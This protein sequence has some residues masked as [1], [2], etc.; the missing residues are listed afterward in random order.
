MST[1]KCVAIAALI[2]SVAGGALAQSP[3]P[4]AISKPTSAAA[5]LMFRQGGAAPAAGPSLLTPAP[6]AR[7]ERGSASEAGVIRSRVAALD[8]IG[9]RALL[10]APNLM[11]DQDGRP[12]GTPPTFTL[13]LFDDISVRL[14]K[15]DATEDDFGLVSLRAVLAGDVSGTATLVIDRDTVTGSI[16]VGGRYFSILGA[17]EGRHRVFELDAAGVRTVKDDA[18]RPFGLGESG[19]RAAVTRVIEDPLHGAAGRERQSADTTIT[20]MVSYTPAASQVIPNIKSAIALA[21]SDTNT[22]LSNSQI[23]AEIRLVGIDRVDYAENGATMAEVLDDLTNGVGDFDRVQRTRSALRADLVS[24][25]SRTS[26]ACGLAWLNDELDSRFASNAARFGA[27][28]VTANVGGTCLATN[29]LAHE[30][31]HNLGAEHDRFAVTDDVPGPSKFNYGYVDLTGRFRDVM[32]YDDECDQ[33]NVSCEEIPFFSN[34][35][36]MYQGRPIGVAADQP[37]AADVSRKIRATV[38]NAARLDSQLVSPTT[39]ILSVLVD[40]NGRVSSTPAGIDC[41]DKCSAEF[42]SGQQVSLV[43]AASPRAEMR[44]WSGDCAGEGSCSVNM[45]SS[46]AVTATFDPAERSGPIFSTAQ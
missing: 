11:V 1:R 17:G 21:V 15:L 45:A 35:A 28:L 39:P 33:A 19:E 31:G 20:L 2:A 8:L 16:K 25:V 24:V 7:L 12:I 13:A 44:A 34:P 10:A 32:S 41:G 46:K 14:V 30:I 5:S 27:S 23:P 4:I 36:L 3:P 22:V 6:D 40:G 37:A 9:L 38:A 18:R 29:T 26:D 42:S 43:A